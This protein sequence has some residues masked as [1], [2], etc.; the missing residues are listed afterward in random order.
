MPTVRVSVIRCHPLQF[1]ELKKMIKALPTFVNQ[2]QHWYSEA[3]SVIT[4][5]L[6]QRVDDFV[7]LYAKPKTR[8]DSKKSSAIQ[9]EIPFRE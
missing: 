9:H 1:A 4:L 7:K 2:Y 3:L 5:L 6:P 8:K